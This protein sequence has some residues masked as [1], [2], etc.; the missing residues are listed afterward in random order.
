MKDVIINKIYKIK[1]MYIYKVFIFQDFLEFNKTTVTMLMWKI[2][3]LF[4]YVVP[5]QLIFYL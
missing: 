4:Q 2:Q 1:I 3:K 5:F